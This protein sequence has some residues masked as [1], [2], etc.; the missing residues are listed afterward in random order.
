V[1]LGILGGT[2]DPPHLAHLALAEE[3]RTRLGLDRVLFVPAGDP[4]RKAGQDIT[5]A[6]HRLAMVRL[7]V[8]G[9]PHFEVCTLEI[10]RKGP[11][12]T[13][14]TLA[15]LAARYGPEAEL[16]FLM[17]EDALHD[18]P[19]WKE[20]ERIAALARLIVAPRPDL[21]EPSPPPESAIPGLAERLIPLDMPPIDISAT[22]L[23]ERA[24][25]GLSL[26]DQVPPAVAEYIEKQGL[27]RQR[28]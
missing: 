8:A 18:M 9:K 12:Y 6:E 2:F 24:R 19:N 20:P 3:A 5:P 13:A 23:R 14:D 21:P 17:G 4:W 7:A 16:Y 11:S 22:A 1:K 28:G 15:E 10:E 26:R 27:Y 25:R